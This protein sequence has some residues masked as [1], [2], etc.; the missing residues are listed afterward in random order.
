VYQPVQLRR[1]KTVLFEKCLVQSELGSF[2][3]LAP[4]DE[5]HIHLGEVNPSF[6]VRGTKRLF[7]W[8]E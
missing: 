8:C 2:E 4:D 1:L 7:S 5:L 3:V 6:P